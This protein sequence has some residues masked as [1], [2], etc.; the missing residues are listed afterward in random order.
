VETTV[1]TIDPVTVRLTIDVGPE[2]IAPAFDRAARELAAQVRIPGFRPGKAPRK[3][4]EQRLGSGAIAQAAM[5]T[6]LGD[7]F[8]E[9]VRSQGLEAVASPEVDV[10][11]FDEATGCAFTATVEVVPPFEA[12][13]HAGVTV[14]HPEWDVT[15]ADVDEQLSGLR[16][17]FAE[18]EVVDRPAAA[19]DLITIDMRVSV[20]GQELED[21]RVDGA[22]YEV[23]SGGVTPALDEGAVGR[24]AGD[25]LT[26]DDDLPEGYPEHGGKRASFSVTVTDVREKQLPALD[27][28]F[29]ASAAGFDTIEELRADVRSSLLRRRLSTA[30]HELRGRVAEAYVARVEIPLP[31]SLV[32]RE[33]D[34]RLRQL[35]QQADAY[36]T[37]VAELLEAEGLTLEGYA[38]RLREQANITVR[39]QLVLDAL[40]AKLQVPVDAADLEREIV[41]HAQMNGVEPARIAELIRD[42]GTLPSLVGDVQRRKA[43]DAIVAAA[44]IEGA[45]P[46]ELLVELG[47]EDAPA[48]EAGAADDAPA[49]DAV[50]ASA[51]EPADT[52]A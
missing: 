17:R 31:P 24:V 2:R 8:V 10:T 1:E 48:P 27:D 20:D 30:R 15:D 41:R 51:A 39:S 26:Y 16:E 37:S 34:L 14:T 13:D 52:E 32:Q 22:L 43:I 6:T 4:I 3:L 21:A 33:V 11:R 50:D 18:V 40:A 49:A 9:A 12:P 29:A 47:L 5:E 42:Q 35:E 19:G 38:D 45:P 25:V 23:G 7:L 46:A 44:T 28:D 36:R